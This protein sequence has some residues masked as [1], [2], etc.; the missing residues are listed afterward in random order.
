MRRLPRH[1]FGPRFQSFAVP[2]E[3]VAVEEVGQVQHAETADHGAAAVRREL[4]ARVAIEERPRDYPFVGDAAARGSAG[5]AGR[6]VRG[7]HTCAA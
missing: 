6:P 7:S 4:D 5:E 1:Q 3:A 2:A